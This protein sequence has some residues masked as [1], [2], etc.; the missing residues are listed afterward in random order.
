[1]SISVLEQG[2]DDDTATLA[3]LGFRPLAQLVEGA[4]HTLPDHADGLTQSQA[5]EVAELV[6]RTIIVID[7]VDLDMTRV[8][9]LVYD[10]DAKGAKDQGHDRPAD[11]QDRERRDPRQNRIGHRHRRENASLHHDD[12]GEQNDERELRVHD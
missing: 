1:M 9:V 8:F 3:L 7:H 2:L 11:R 4:G 12:A 10:Q 5:H 6:A